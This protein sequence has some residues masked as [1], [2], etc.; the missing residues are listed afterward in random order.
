MKQKSVNTKKMKKN[1]GFLKYKYR[2]ISGLLCV[3]AGILTAGSVLSGA[4][5]IGYSRSKGI[6]FSVDLSRGA[7]SA[8]ESDMLEDE[9]DTAGK[10]EESS[11][12]T[13]AEDLEE[14]NKAAGAD[15]AQKRAEALHGEEINKEISEE[16]IDSTDVSDNVEGD[17]SADSDNGTEAAEEVESEENEKT[18]DS[19]ENE[20]GGN[21]GADEAEGTAEPVFEVWSYD[22]D[23]LN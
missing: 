18:D 6:K 19:E 15:T 16:T 12:E 10:R 9:F 7:I 2:L 11:G 1:R 13:E 3:M 14:N 4:W 5:H 20:A 17:G 8:E 21:D 22:I 23:T